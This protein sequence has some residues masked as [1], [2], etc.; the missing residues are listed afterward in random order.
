MSEDT[1]MVC[2]TPDYCARIE[3]V[4]GYTVRH[5]TVRES[6]PEE[7]EPGGVGTFWLTG[8]ALAAARYVVVSDDGEYL[9]GFGGVDGGD[10]REEAVFWADR[11]ASKNGGHFIRPDGWAEVVGNLPE[12]K[13]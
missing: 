2:D 6:T 1:R 12:E 7:R 9:G 3:D 4:Y 13:G 10:T 8:K 11:W 5:L